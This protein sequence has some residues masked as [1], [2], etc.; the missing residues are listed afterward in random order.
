MEIRE[1]R[2]GV[3]GKL[4]RTTAF[5]LSLAYLLLFSIGAGLVLTRVGARVKEVLDEQIE[6]TVEGEIRA[7]SEQYAQ[8]GLRDLTEA[9]ERRVRAPGGSLYLL[10]SASGDIIAGNIEPPRFAPGG[11]DILIETL[12]RRR[13]EL[14]EAHP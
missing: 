9:V 8:G 6:Q 11:G 3:I 10:T 1:R 14:E 5:K 12:Y 7:L 13:G 2:L 4:F